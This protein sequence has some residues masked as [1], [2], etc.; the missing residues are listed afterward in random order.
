MAL[1]IAGERDLRDAVPLH[2]TGRQQIE[3]GAER[4][5]RTVVATDQQDAIDR[6]LARRALQEVAGLGEARQ[7]P[8]SDMRHGDETGATQ[9]RTGGDDVMMRHAG[10]VVD[11]YGRA[12][13]EQLAQRIAGE[14]VTRRQFDANSRRSAPLC[15]DAAVA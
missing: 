14:F 15:A 7:P 6:R 2:D 11:E 8:R 3:A 12:R 10:R 9:P 1:G 4:P 13:I 5:D